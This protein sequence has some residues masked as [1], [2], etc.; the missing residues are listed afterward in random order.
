MQLRLRNLGEESEGMH[1]HE[2]TERQVSGPSVAVH[3]TDTIMD[4]GSRV[5][6]SPVPI[7]LAP[8]FSQPLTLTTNF[9]G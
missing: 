3:D 2:A 4:V 1:A 6:L 7:S 5:E 9:T 8:T